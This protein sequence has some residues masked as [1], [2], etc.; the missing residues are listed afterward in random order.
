LIVA[1]AL[2]LAGGV[3]HPIVGGDSHSAETIAQS[4]FPIAHFLVFLGAAFLLAGLPG[5]YARIAPAAGKL[6]FAGFILYFFAN[7]TLVM[8]FA[9]Y[10]AF[11]APVLAGDP[12]T[13]SLVGPDGAIPSSNGFAV[14]EGI[15]GLTYMVALFV[16]GIAVVRSRMMPRWTGVLLAIS[17]LL[18][19]LPVPERSILTGLLV[20]L[21]RG[22][23]VAA[24]GYVLYTSVRRQP[25]TLSGIEAAQPE[26]QA[27]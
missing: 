22:L 27:A 6:E 7:A 3:L 1:F 14:I 5:L 4:R 9:G 12:A 10:E 20:E 2:S 26:S 15:G 8:F 16:L 11:V 17:P 23:A 25:A 21:P 24:M 13:S 18:L 19:L